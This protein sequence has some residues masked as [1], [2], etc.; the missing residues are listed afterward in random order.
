M[1]EG[2]A[3]S[4]RRISFRTNRYVRLVAI[5]SLRFGSD[6]GTHDLAPADRIGRAMLKC[7]RLGSG[8]LHGGEGDGRVPRTQRIGRVITTPILVMLGSVWSVWFGLVCLV[9]STSV[10]GGRLGG[11]AAIWSVWSGS[12]CLVGCH[13]VVLVRLEVSWGHLGPPLR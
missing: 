4:V 11:I 7:T 13:G 8:C 6:H 1:G 10:L 9:W 2:E 5:E 12:V 3:P